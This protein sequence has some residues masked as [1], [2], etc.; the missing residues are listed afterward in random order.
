MDVKASASEIGSAHH[1]FLQLVSIE[2]TGSITEL[3]REVQRLRQEL[4]MTDNELEL[5]NIDAL[6]VFWNSDL[7]KQ[8]RASRH[9]LHREL[10]FTARFSIQA[11]ASLTGEPLASSLPQEFVVIQGVADLVVLKPSEIWLV[12]FKTDSIKPDT[13]AARAKFYEPQMKLYAT[14]LA[15]IYRRPVAACWVYF[16]ECSTAI[17]ISV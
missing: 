9:E 2:S 8:I 10:E 12:D 6:A 16:L 11:L 15:Q 14:A 1:R 5:L 17:A 13:L 3:K 4:A 7:G